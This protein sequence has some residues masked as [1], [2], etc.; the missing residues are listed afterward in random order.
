ML[1]EPVNATYKS[2]FRPRL[3]QDAE[4]FEI[5]NIFHSL[6]PEFVNEESA[7]PRFVQS[8]LNAYTLQVQSDHR[9]HRKGASFR[10]HPSCEGHYLYEHSFEK[11]F[12]I[13]GNYDSNKDY[14][15]LEIIGS[16]DFRR[17]SIQTLDE[18]MK[19]LRMQKIE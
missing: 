7:G 5:S 2:I 1:Q 16:V 15:D 4:I 11:R 12:L 8:L 18:A 13:N 17:Q 10:T 3:N 9:F 6:K 14:L 19:A